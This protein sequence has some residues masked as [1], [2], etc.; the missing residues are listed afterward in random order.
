MKKRYIILILFYS[1]VSIAQT[2]T[3]T[4]Q[5]TLP[6][7]FY[8]Q[9]GFSSKRQNSTTTPANQDIILNIKFHTVYGSNGYNQFNIDESHYF[10]IVEE[11]NV[12]FNRLGIYFKY[13]GFNS[14]ND[15][16][17]RSPVGAA[18][19]PLLVQ[20]FKD[21]GLYDYN[22]LNFFYN[23]QGQGGLNA[24]GSG[25]S[26]TGDTFMTPIFVPGTLTF[27]Y[28]VC[29]EIGHSL[30]L[31]HTDS[32]QYLQ[33]N[34][35]IPT[36]VQFLFNADGFWSY[37]E[38]VTR[39]PTN[40]NYNADITGDRVE[41]TGA[42]FF[43]QHW[44]Y[45]KD[46]STLTYNYITDPRVVDNSGDINTKCF[47]CFATQT[48]YTY[49]LGNNF[50]TT[51]QSG[52]TADILL[53][54]STWQN[55]VDT[56]LSNCTSV[57]SGEMYDLSAQ[58]LNYMVA[59]LNQ[60]DASKSLTIG[61]GN[62]IKENVLNVRQALYSS[63]LCVT[64]DNN[65]DYTVLYEPFTMNSGNGISATTAYSR[66]YMANTNNT[67]ADVWNCGPFNMRF[68]TGFNCEFYN[69][70]GNTVLQTPDQQYNISTGTG[71]GV[72]IPSL[73]QYIHYNAAPVCF[74][75]FEPYTSGN[76]KSL[77]NLGVGTYTQEEL[78]RIKASDPH[79]YE[80]LQSGKYHIIT[81]QTDSGFS[82]QKIIHK[83]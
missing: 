11:L 28:F 45:C 83:N 36:C 31:A 54:N 48:K 25:D 1:I 55:I 21:R 39:D 51:L 68:Q 12:E 57:R 19:N 10:K 70:N 16:A 65:P 20:A 24:T 32:V 27:K 77:D 46:S 37:S 5:F 30:G 59:G 8:T 9:N 72:K 29:H 67:G 7:D 78:D 60:P 15:D 66:T 82:D 58:P 14:F 38:N 41:D 26:A 71:I 52:I 50:Y 35:N 53:G 56:T 61:Q 18:G 79:L 4:C 23:C 34:N 75:S 73:G 44:N 76:V 13:R 81:K 6:P 64:D 49:S 80:Q 40:I 33:I 22:A 63:K 74:N 2:N 47:F 42:A 17:L 3:S 69:T 62:R 43:L